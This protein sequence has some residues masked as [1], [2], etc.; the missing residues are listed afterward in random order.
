[1][2]DK[3]T[4]LR[5]KAQRIQNPAKAANIRNELQLLTAARAGFS[6]AGSDVDMIGL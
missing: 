4:I 1:L 3:V 6:V 2:I 5:I